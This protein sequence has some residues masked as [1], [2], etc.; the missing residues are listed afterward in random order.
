[1]I[2]RPPRST[3]TDT[4]FPYTTLFRSISRSASV[5]ESGQEY[6]D[7]GGD[8]CGPFDCGWRSAQSQQHLEVEIAA[9][10]SDEMVAGRLCVA[11][12]DLAA[13]LG[14][15]KHLR[16]RRARETRADI[17]EAPPQIRKAHLLGTPIAITT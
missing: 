10:H 4:L 3:R 9:D 16:K 2:R 11:R 6:V 13:R 8:K 15:S 7:R 12:A 14:R 17:G 5:A 1:M